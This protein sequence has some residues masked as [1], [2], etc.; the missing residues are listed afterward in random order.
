MSELELDN[1]TRRKKEVLK[2]ACRAIA[3]SVMTSAEKKMEAERMAEEKR[4]NMEKLASCKKFLPSKDL[5]H[6]LCFE[7]KACEMRF[8]DL[9][10]SRTPVGNFIIEGDVQAAKLF[11]NSMKHGTPVF[12]MKGTGGA[13]DKISLVLDHMKWRKLL[14]MDGDDTTN[15]DDNTAAKEDE[16]IRVGPFSVSRDSHAGWALQGLA[17]S[18]CCCCSTVSSDQAEHRSSTRV[19][20]EVDD[21]NQAGDAIDGSSDKLGL[22]IEA[23]KLELDTA[24]KD[25]EKAEEDGEFDRALEHKQKWDVINELSERADKLNQDIKGLHEKMMHEVT[26]A[27]NMQIGL[28]WQD[29]GSQEPSPGTGTDL[30]AIHGFNS[31]FL[32]AQ[33]RNKLEFSLEEWQSFKFPRLKSD[34]Y[35]KVDDK[36]FQTVE[37]PK[38]LNTHQFDDELWRVHSDYVELQNDYKDQKKNSFG[39]T[40]S[41]KRVDDGSSAGD[42]STGS[43]AG[44]HVMSAMNL[45]F[46]KADNPENVYKEDIRVGRE[47]LAWE[48]MHGTFESWW[49]ANKDRC[50]PNT[51]SFELDEPDSKPPDAWFL[52][53][54]ADDWNCVKLKDRQT[55]VARPCSEQD[56][57]FCGPVSITTLYELSPASITRSICENDTEI[58]A[59]LIVPN[60]SRRG[61]ALISGDL[62]NRVVS[63]MNWVC[64][65]KAST[66]AF[67]GIETCSRMMT[68][69][70]CILT[71]L[72]CAESS[73]R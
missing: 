68:R 19:R 32:A 69:P 33:L 31:D 10:T 11:S 4:L 60:R 45:P 38:D 6:L 35:I 24:K 16:A 47:G 28:K 36:F 7:S 73:I 17:N 66:F 56:C 70:I 29:I 9:L 37:I 44:D 3:K 23:L 57:E 58:S 1:T 2:E 51:R 63:G 39:S 5:T 30:S 50:P 71:Q 64:W 46:K 13:S 41:K 59:R 18:V 8:R 14:D 49:K 72:S 27:E 21:A 54:E 65:N 25:R 53:H 42:S 22:M 20:D 26:V 48:A 55:N 34:S 15:L 40:A 67:G 62:L 52:P 12:I 61:S 43:G